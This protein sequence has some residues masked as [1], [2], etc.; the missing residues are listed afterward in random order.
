[1][2]RQS[3]LTRI[4]RLLR[5]TVGLAGLFALF[6]VGGC[7]DSPDSVTNPD[8][9]Q[10]DLDTVP[11]MSEVMTEVDLNA[12]QAA[13]V[14]LALEEW[15]SLAAA[16]VVIEDV[17]LEDSPA[18]VFLVRIAPTLSAAQ[19]TVMH[20]LVAASIDARSNGLAPDPMDRGPT[21]HGGIRGLF[22]GLEL[23]Q[24]QSDAI[25]DALEASRNGV[26]DLCEQF[27]DGEIT[28]EELRTGRAELRAELAA[29]IDAVLTEEQRAQ[30]EENKLQILTRRLSTL[31]LHYEN[32]IDSR[33]RRL[34]ALLDL[35]DEQVK[36]VTSVLMDARADLEA[37]RNS[38]DTQEVGSAEAWDMFR[39][40]QL[41]TDEAV[42]AEL[43]EA[44]RQILDDLRK[45]HEPCAMGVEL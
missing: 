7:S 2:Y 39:S 37:L 11:S 35:S 34:D 6:T 19:M 32:R 14:E 17:L 23:T 45:I 4:P 5:A 26:L 8:P 43:T 15:R 44:Q 31:L 27:R 33:V 38:A 28:E 12:E 25:R 29:A 22:N 18:M 40:L 42:S 10:N 41:E 30:F 36:E 24:E 21:L 3:T 16:S 20:R 1:M 9:S 13:E